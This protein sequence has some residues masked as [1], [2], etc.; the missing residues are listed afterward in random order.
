MRTF[1]LLLDSRSSRCLVLVSLFHGMERWVAEA[2]ASGMG[3]TKLE[4][5]NEENLL[6]LHTAHL[7]PATHSPHQPQNRRGDNH[8]SQIRLPANKRQ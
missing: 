8:I 1:A 2:G 6:S 4:L 7:L 3:I 5:G